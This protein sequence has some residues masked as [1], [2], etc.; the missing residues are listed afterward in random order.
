MR[1]E[2]EQPSNESGDEEIDSFHFIYSATL[3]QYLGF[4]FFLEIN[5][6]W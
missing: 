4:V 5:L 1:D 3:H 6:V 2:E